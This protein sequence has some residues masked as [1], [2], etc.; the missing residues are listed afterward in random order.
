VVEDMRGTY[1]S[2]GAAVL[3][4]EQPWAE[5]GYDTVEWVASQPWS[6]GKV[7]TWGLSALGAQQYRTAVM[8]PPHLAAAVPIFCKANRSYDQVYATGVLRQEYYDVL[9]LYLGGKIVKVHPTHDRYWQAYEQELDLAAVG[10]PMLVVSGWWDLYNGGALQDFLALRTLSAPAVRDS[11]RLLLGPWIHYALG[12]A[13]AGL[14]QDLDDQ[15]RLFLDTAQRIQQDSLAFFDLHLRG[16]QSPAATWAPARWIPGDGTGSSGIEEAGPTFPPA[17]AVAITLYLTPG[18]ALEPQ[19]PAPVA[20]SFPYDPDSPS[21]T[22]GGA[23]LALTLE[24]GPRGQDEVVARGDAVTF[25]GAPLDSPLAVRGTVTTELEVATSG[26]DTDFAV[27]LTDVD[28][29]GGHMLVGDGIRRLKLRDSFEQPAAVVP[30][31][32]YSI[33][34]TLFNLVGYTFAAGHRVGLILSSSNFPRFAL[35]PNTGADFCGLLP[36]GAVVTNTVYLGAGSRLV[37]PTGD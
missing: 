25:V 20:L 5:D 21:P 9:K 28:P 33:R 1:G 34:V 23:T 3:A 15:E 16:Q 4:V 29:A 10:V 19:A 11:H 31:E 32:R 18:G 14:P 12:G 8:Q 7:G 17:G 13:N 26:A 2:V 22:Q 24:H 35:N 37:L 36:D 27:R 30:G 6:D